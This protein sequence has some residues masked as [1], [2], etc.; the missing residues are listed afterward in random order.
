MFIRGHD[1]HVP[2]GQQIGFFFSLVQ[3]TSAKKM[4]FDTLLACFKCP[5][6][7]VKIM[8]P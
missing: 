4:S 7:C 1:R 2:P 8:Q 6:Y 3:K 5:K